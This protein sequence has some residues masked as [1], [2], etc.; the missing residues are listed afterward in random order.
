MMRLNKHKKP[1]K[2]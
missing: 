2:T 1:N